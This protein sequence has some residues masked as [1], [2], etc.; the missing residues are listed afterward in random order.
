MEQPIYFVRKVY[1]GDGT[2]YQ[3]IERLALVVVVNTR[4]LR[5]HFRENLVMVKTNYP[6]RQVLKK[7]NLIARMV[8]WVVELSEYS[9]Q[10]IPRG[11]IKSH[12]LAICF[13]IIQFLSRR[14]GF[15]HLDYIN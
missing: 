2:Q 13:S 1:K 10:Y 14:G 11:S 6:I 3:K 4:K 7:P 5:L 8:Y 12:V 9:I 15:P